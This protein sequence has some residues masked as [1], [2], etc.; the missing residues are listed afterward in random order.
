MVEMAVTAEIAA[1]QA[2]GPPVAPLE[3]TLPALAMPAP[4]GQP[5]WA[6]MVEPAVPV[7][8]RPTRTWLP[9]RVG[10]AVTQAHMATAGRVAPVV[11]GR[12]ELLVKMG[13]S[14]ATVAQPAVPAAKAGWAV[15]AGWAVQSP[16]MVVRV[17]PEG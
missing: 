1:P 4:P 15:R 3:E 5:V 7:G 14:P 2:P 8:T 11:M 9:A 13:N 10:P 6:A 16:A 17:A 12:L